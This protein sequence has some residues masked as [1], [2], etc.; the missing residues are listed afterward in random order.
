M[1][2]LL[3]SFSEEIAHVS[4]SINSP[5]FSH[6][7]RG[8]GCWRDQVRIYHFNPESPTGVILDTSGDYR[9]VERLLSE[10]TKPFP[11]SPTE[12]Y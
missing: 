5:N 11:L 8:D 7:R 12:R 3:E 1:H 2:K 6:T 10:K 9:L 4:K